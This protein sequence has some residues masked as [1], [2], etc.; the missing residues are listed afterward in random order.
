MN[1]KMDK[2]KKIDYFLMLQN[3]GITIAFNKYYGSSTEQVD[4]E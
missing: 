1:T 2:N 3:N 4:K